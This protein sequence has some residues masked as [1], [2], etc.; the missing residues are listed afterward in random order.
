V[1]LRLA[2][3]VSHPIQYYVP[4]YQRLAN[5][6]DVEIKV[7]FT[8]HD[9]QR[10]VDDRGFKA[11]VA[12]DIPLRQ[13]YEFELVRNTSSDPGTHKFFGLRNPSLV[14]R[15]IAW[16]PDVVHITG[17]AWFSHLN[18]L[19][20]LSKMGIPTLFRGDSHLLDNRQIGIRWW[21]KRT[22]LKHVFSWPAG[23]LV[24]GTANRAYY[25]A[26]G[27]ESNRLFPCPHSIDVDRFRRP[28]KMLE[29]EAARYRQRLG[30]SRNQ[31]VLLF[32]GKFERKKCPLELMRAVLALTNPGL[33]LVMVGGGELEAEVKSIAERDP[34]R[35][36]VLP[37]QNQS[38]MPVVYRVGDL[39]VLPS[40]FSESWGLAVNE[41]LAS[42]RPVLVSD[43]VGCAADV[44]DESCGFV[45]SWD[46]TCALVRALSE[47]LDKRDRLMEMGQA[48]AK[49]ASSFDITRTEDA[50]I[51]CLLQVC[52]R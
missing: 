24:T 44:V 6:S 22:L 7:F 39:L 20:A 9:G 33:V 34:E 14:R 48:A 10:A 13:G 28:A 2:I 1:K 18:V 40:A 8:W 51:N 23:F 27:V 47:I 25:E 26:F 15:V 46:D 38:R 19:R 52:S 45:F 50:I 11:L 4:L 30:I 16:Q 17:W 29:E 37:F 36:R 32:A 12:W 35:F 41:A 3:I 42:G 43:R 21:T 5:R 49:R 31:C